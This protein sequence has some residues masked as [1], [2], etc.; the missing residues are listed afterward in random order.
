MDLYYIQKQSITYLGSNV[1]IQATFEKA[2]ICGEFIRA[3]SQTPPDFE[4]G[5]T[6]ST[7]H[8]ISSLQNPL[9]KKNYLVKVFHFSLVCSPKLIFSLL[10][11]HI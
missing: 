5:P 9:K 10:N 7:R 3:N 6:A 8:R 1:G 4:R 11:H 2:D